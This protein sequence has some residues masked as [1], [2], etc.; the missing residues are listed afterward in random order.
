MSDGNQKQQPNREYPP[1]YERIV[2]IAIVLIAAAVI[3]VLF[4]IFGVA[5]GLFPG[6]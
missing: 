5:L 1:L 3:V 2:P 6:S 4:I